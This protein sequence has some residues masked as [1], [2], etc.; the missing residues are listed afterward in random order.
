[1]LRV[2]K[3]VVTLASLEQIGVEKGDNNN[4]ETLQAHSEPQF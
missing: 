3:K 1:M 2:K 4:E